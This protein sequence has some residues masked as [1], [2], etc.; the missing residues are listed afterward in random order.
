MDAR[1]KFGE[2]WASFSRHLNEDDVKEAERSLNSLFG[3][4]ALNGKTFLDIGCG[5]GLFSIAAARLGARQVVGIDVDP[6]SVETSQINA[7][8]WLE[9]K[10]SVSFLHGSA[11]DAAQMDALGSFDVVY[12]WGVLHHTG[13]M[14]R[15]IENTVRRVK[16]DG[17]LMIAIY[18]RHS[19]ST[20]WKAIKWLY[21]RSNHF[22]QKLLIWFFTPIIFVAKWIS[23]GGNPLKMRRGMD[24]M[25][26]V[27]DW[28]GGYPYEYAS[29]AEMS[30]VLERLGFDVLKTN[31]AIVPTGCNEFVCKH[32]GEKSLPAENNKT[33]VTA[34]R[35][36]RV[37]TIT[38]IVLALAL[39]GFILSRTSLDELMTLRRQLHLDWLAV[40]AL[41]Y[42]TLTAFKAY[43]YRKLLDLPVPYARVV[44]IVVLQN[45][46]SNIVANSAGIASYLVMFRE[47]KGVKVSHAALVFIITKVGDVFAVWL[48]LLISSVILWE[49]VKV[50]HDVIILLLALLG[51]LLFIFLLAVSLRE[52]FVI[53]FKN[54]I[55]RMGLIRFSLITQSIKGLEALAA[56][57][58]GSLFEMTWNAVWLSSAYFLLTL[59]WYYAQL[60]LFS[61]ALGIWQIVFATTILQLIS[62]IP[63]T[64]LGGLGVVE[65]SSLYLYSIF[66]VDP[67]K[68]AAVL[69]GMRVVFY[70]INLV[71]LLYLPLY[72]IIENQKKKL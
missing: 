20:P 10:D 31:P 68:F 28:V 36:S 70:M 35:S 56:Q 12:S 29:I 23:T 57:G 2:N 22:G 69:I 47:E 6:M 32:R 5:S 7:A 71:V 51:L 8:R 41:L 13:N 42:L 59:A 24:F 72:S 4:G 65:T 38:K 18:N 33:T 58:R 26:N 61:V 37:W 50:L 11:L 40:Y 53:F 19:S 9:N 27:I 46:F 43:Q 55:A 67:I 39:I 17:L 34:A 16:P 62:I 48:G 64:I 54:I 15:S 14:E 63:I 52:R 25:Y 60:R 3:E 1:F 44:S 66:G 49:Q 45:G 30:A 21:N